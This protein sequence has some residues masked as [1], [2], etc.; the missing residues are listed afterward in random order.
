MVAFGAMASRLVRDDRYG[1]D[2]IYPF[3]LWQHDP[4]IVRQLEDVI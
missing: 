1:Q 4:K 3:G 2:C